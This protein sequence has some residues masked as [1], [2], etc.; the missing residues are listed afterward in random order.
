MGK[1]AS[2]LALGRGG[3]WD[4]V[5]RTRPQES[6]TSRSVPAVPAVAGLVTGDALAA[7]KAAERKAFEAVTAWL[8]GFGLRLE[9]TTLDALLRQ[10]G[11]LLSVNKP[12]N[13]TPVH[14]PPVNTVVNKPVNTKPVHAASVNTPV[15][16]GDE[17]ARKA[18]R[19]EWM[20]RRRAGAKGA[21]A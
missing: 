4:Q 11:P 6:A 2:Q 21:K 3:I 9:A 20:A 13:A 14:E 16:T 8:E 5:A 15:N 19:R 18:Y 17:E 1:L 7:T 12:V 10:A